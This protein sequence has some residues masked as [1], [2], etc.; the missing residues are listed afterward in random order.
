MYR[1]V[2]CCGLA[3]PFG[4]LGAA[5]FLD[6]AVVTNFLTVPASHAWYFSFRLEG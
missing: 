3:V 2:T 1:F 4:E 6:R 5:A